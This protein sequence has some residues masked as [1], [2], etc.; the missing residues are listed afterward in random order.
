MQISRR[1]DGK[2][3]IWYY[4]KLERRSDLKPYEERSSNWVVIGV[5]ASWPEADQRRQ[6][7]EIVIAASQSGH[8]GPDDGRPTSEQKR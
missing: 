1:Y 8:N 5:A 3:N 2:Y 6:A 4:D 7:H